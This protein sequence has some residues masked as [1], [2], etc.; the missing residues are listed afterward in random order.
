MPTLYPRGAD[1]DALCGTRN[2]GGAQWWTMDEKELERIAVSIAVDAAALI[3]ETAAELGDIEAGVRWKSS[4]VDPVTVVD[5]AAERFI[6]QRLTQ[7][8]PQD[9][10]FGEE[11]HTRDSKSGVVWAVDPI[12]GTVNF[13]Y[14]QPAYAVSMA[15]TVDGIAVAGAVVAV[16]GATV[17]AASK[18]NGAWRQLQGRRPEPLRVSAA[19]ELHKSLIATGFG[20]DPVRRQRQ[21]ELLTTVLPRVRDIRRLGS[22][23]LDLCMLAAGQV[24]AFYEHGLNAWDYAAGALIAAEA[25][26]EVHTPL[27]DAPSHHGAP[28]R[29]AAPGIADAFFEL[30]PDM[31]LPAGR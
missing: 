3:R 17:Y 6:A 20:Y 1:F 2:P 16:P 5:E 9:G 26:A 30:V 21:A 24:D 27:L 11:G 12:D 22:A 18:S 31:P 4:D 14:G 19:T 10:F 13:L 7:L 8:R 25:G 23:A 28:V 29:A 15:A